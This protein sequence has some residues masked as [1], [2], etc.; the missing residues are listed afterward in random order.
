MASIGD[1]LAAIF[2]GLRQDIK[3]VI[4]AN[5]AETMKISGLADNPST[6]IPSRRDIT[7]GVKAAPIPYPV[8]SPIGIPITDSHSA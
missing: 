4:S 6:G 8:I 1:T 7:I 2:P 5:R 3:T